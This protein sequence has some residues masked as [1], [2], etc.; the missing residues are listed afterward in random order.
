M[1]VGAFEPAIAVPAVAVH[2]QV[3]VLGHLNGFALAVGFLEA[4]LAAP[5]A[6]MG[7]QERMVGYLDAFAFHARICRN[8]VAALTLPAASVLRQIRV[9]G[10]ANRLAHPIL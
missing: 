1:A 8:R 10:H 6:A 7:G 4:S 5:V 3:S 9:F 2:L